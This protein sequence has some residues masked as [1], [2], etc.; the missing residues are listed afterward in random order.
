MK[1][2]NFLH[3]RD[4]HV[5]HTTDLLTKQFS[6]YQYWVHRGLLMH[7]HGLYNYSTYCNSLPMT[8]AGVTY[9]YTGMGT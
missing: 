4:I 2:E 3:Y 5:N 1:T 7:I 9:M 8:L 6:S